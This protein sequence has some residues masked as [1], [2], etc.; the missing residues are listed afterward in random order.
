MPQWTSEQ[1]KV[2]DL[3]NRNILVSAAAG[4]GKTAV[5][6]ERI[7]HMI[8]EGDNPIDIDRLVIVTFTK[9]A[10]AEMRSRISDAIEKKIVQ[11]PD[12]IHLQRQL[13]LIHN[14][15]ITTI[16]SF[17]LNIV[18]NYFN[19][20]DME[21]DFKVG[22]EGELK[23]I[24]QDVMDQLLEEYYA[25]GRQEFYDFVESY[26][27]GKTDYGISDYIQKMYLLSQSN[28]W[29]EEWLDNILKEYDMV[30]TDFDNTEC[31]KYRNRHLENMLDSCIEELNYGLE[32]AKSPGGPYMYVDNLLDD[33]ELVQRFRK[34]RN[35][36][37][38]K[39][40]RLSAK[41]D[42]SVNPSLREQVKALRTAVTSDIK[43]I[44][45]EYGSLNREKEIEDIA[46]SAP[47]M[48]MLVE[49]T[50]EYTKRFDAA[51]KEK[52][53]INFN[54]ME[55][56][57]LNILVKK[58]DGKLVYSKT[59]DELSKL[60]EEI[61]IDEYQD[62]NMV[63]EILL[64]SISRERYGT[65]N[66]FMVGDVKQSIYRFRLAR[67]ELFVEKHESYTKEDSSYQKIELHKN[68]RS[69]EIILN[70]CN[71]IFDRV[72][73]KDIGNVEYDEE[74]RL[75]L[76]AQ[77]QPEDNLNEKTEVMLLEFD[78]DRDYNKIEAQAITMA[79]RIRDMV[80]PESDVR[81]WNDSK[82]AYTVPEYRDIVILTR[83]AKE[84][85]DTI[86]NVLMNQGIPA[87]TDSQTGY[88][89]AAE[90]VTVLN[91]LSV[92]D[93]P[94]QD[95]P[96]TAVLKSYY[97]G[98]TDDE[99][100]LLRSRNKKVSMYEG[101][102]A[103]DNPKLHQ[104][105]E[106]L[107]QYRE[108]VKY[109][110]VHD[111]IWKLVYDTGYYDYLSTMPAGRRRQQNVDMLI[112]KAKSYENTS[113]RG[114]FNFLRYIEKLKSFDI[115]YGEAA[116]GGENDNVVRV[117]TIHK[118]KGL[119]FPIVF[120][121]GME[122]KFN[123]MDAKQKIVFDADLGVGAD[124]VALDRRTKTPTV[125][126]KTIQK[127]QK[128]DD[129]GE[130]LRVL[131]VA[132]TRAKEKLI[133]LGSVK[134]VEKSEEKWLAE[135]RKESISYSALEKKSSYLELVMPSAYQNQQYFE[136]NRI[137]FNPGYEEEAEQYTEEVQEFKEKKKF[138]YP[139]KIVDIPA[140][141][142]VSELKHVGEDYDEEKSTKLIEQEEE[143]Q[144]VPEFLCGERE[145]TG[146]LR[147]S[148]Y[149]LIMECLD[150]NYADSAEHIKE[151]IQILTE[152]G[153]IT[154]EWADSVDPGDI[155]TFCNTEFGRNVKEAFFAGKLYREKQFVMGVEAREIDEQYD[156]DELI[157]VQGIIDI[158][159]EKDGKI[160][161][162]DYKTDRVKRGKEGEQELIRRYHNQLRYYKKAVEQILGKTVEHL[163]IY[164]FALGKDIYLE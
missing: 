111:V 53:I 37:E 132:L 13:T 164:S 72:M 40:S 159:Y 70:S 27:L 120:V 150:Y 82:K 144:I 21:P 112:E 161:I 93:N 92:I 117:M 28:P 30:Q 58:E 12:N 67:P 74:A 45:E 44:V 110:P 157:L 163:V 52:N 59:A 127:K 23:M 113:Y 75:N 106:F 153:K 11:H 96:L 107:L 79:D 131:Y 105:N 49:L 22:D 87:C 133:L 64:N 24:A 97:A 39:F 108:L 69:K 48:K 63:Q 4:S 115:D 91:M 3:H 142:T 103:S 145:V 81:V 80:S 57:A 38:V 50:R 156:T 16:D 147:G 54:D 98:L 140:K 18:K 43:N 35:Y 68:F 5:L 123:T 109:T 1:Q 78:E 130:E 84:W 46:I 114:V 65:P 15:Q 34:N 32:V 25:E 73:K 160:T 119:E 116:S 9:A 51:K 124:Y 71:C 60:Y 162:G 83:T 14:A 99:I 152:R 149:H 62:S 7:I 10:A 88:F 8:A 125:I 20:I 29:P 2:I 141:M 56:M 158:Y 85:A 122:K 47:L 136:V 19:E 26:S 36:S 151:Y 17:C 138:V 101:M 134:D 118:S 31:V 135:A 76:G 6:V 143:T 95:I 89:A 148:A 100:A 77:Y 128:L 55:H 129:L 41:K 104:F 42:D 154:R 121:A 61:L 146:S 86:V 126:K 94:K 137:P 155:Y 90:V 66:V 139:Y 102:L 33:M